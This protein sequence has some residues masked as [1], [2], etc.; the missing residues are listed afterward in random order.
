MLL[1]ELKEREYRFRLA[2]RMGLPIFALIIALISHTLIS[3]YE[4]L[5][6]SFY[7]ESSLLLLFSIYFLFFLIYKGS[8]EKITD[9]I[10]KTFSREYLYE[11]LKK[12]I[13]KEHSYTL[14]LVSIDNLSDINERYGIKIGDKV[15]YETASW[16]ADFFISKKI[17]NF[18]IGHIRSANFIIGLPKEKAHYK[19]IL[20]L[21]SIKASEL[22]LNEIEITISTSMIDTNFSHELDHLVEKLFELQTIKKTIKNHSIDEPEFNPGELESLV[23]KAV[24][25]KNFLFM[26]QDIFEAERVV[27][28][29]CFVKLKTDSQMI[30]HQ[31]DYIKILNKLGLSLQFDLM[32]LEKVTSDC[33][34]DNALLYAINISPTSIRNKRFFY[35]LRNILEKKSI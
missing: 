13:L 35:E 26:H 14:L 19:A 28:K 29:E 21:L 32:I 16:I 30:I 27:A 3:S 25:D 20:E 5:D 10:S 31:K 23:I 33:M 34:N 11:Y 1:P 6:V 24:A 18:P 4:S 8:N 7:I 12:E 22:K 9:P 17:I 15:I 2:L